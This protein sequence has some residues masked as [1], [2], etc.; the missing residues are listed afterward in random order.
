MINWRR[1]RA[2]DESI[3]QAVERKLG[4]TLPADYRKTI[5][6]NSGG[7]PDKRVFAV[8][9]QERVF[10]RLLSAEAD[11]HPNLVDALAWTE[12]GSRRLVPFA[13]DPFGNMLC[14]AYVTDDFCTVAFAEA[15][16]G[17]ITPVSPSF[18]AFLCLLGDR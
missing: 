14:F 11:R 13:T 1:G 18:T 9:G 3:L 16:S 15:E 12:G 4:V 17:E 6:T 2:A 7:V 8:R 5:L 10:S